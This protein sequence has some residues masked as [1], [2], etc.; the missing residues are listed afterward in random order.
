MG[1]EDNGP[2]IK[3]LKNGPYVV[4]GGVPLTRVTITSGPDGDPAEW[5]ESQPLPT[6]DR[7]TL[8]R[9]GR[10]S[11]KPFCDGSHFEVGFD[12]TE[13]ASREPYLERAVLLAGP[14]VDVTDTQ[15]LCA[16]ARVSVACGT[17]WRSA[18][19]ARRRTRTARVIGSVGVG[20]PSSR[21]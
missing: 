9:C 21:S 16:E 6:Q 13:T 7:Y 12:G 17:W 3:V 10:S 2:R 18:G 14:G 20:P 1:E 19:Q 11:N 4:S 15:D 8:C 5:S